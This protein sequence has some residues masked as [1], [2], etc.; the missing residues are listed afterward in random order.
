MV[1]VRLPPPLLCFRCRHTWRPVKPAIVRCPALQVRALAHAATAAA[2]TAAE[3][4]ARINRSQREGEERMKQRKQVPTSAP[5]RR[6]RAQFSVADRVRV[7]NRCLTGDVVELAQD[8]AQQRVALIRFDDGHEQ[9]QLTGDLRRLPPIPEAYMCAHCG[10]IVTYRLRRGVCREC[11]AAS[12]PEA[13]EG[14]E[15]DAHEKK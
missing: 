3:G 4:A 6:S 15:A 7:P 8:T 14:E 12:K 5:A 13:T 2:R 10:V 11:A 1:N 9:W